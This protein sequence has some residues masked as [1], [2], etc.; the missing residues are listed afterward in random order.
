VVAEYAASTGLKELGMN[1][2][3][4][5]SMMELHAIAR[6]GHAS[7]LSSAVGTP[8]IL[9]AIHKIMRISLNGKFFC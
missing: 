6:G 9:F 3:T 5:I 2:W 7:N 8:N 1:D 4:I